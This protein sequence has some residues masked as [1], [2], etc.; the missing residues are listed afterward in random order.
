MI[1]Q[2]SLSPSAQAQSLR[3]RLTAER[4]L[5]ELRG[6]A[7]GHCA[8]VNYLKRDEA[9]ETC[10]VLQERART[11]E[12]WLLAYVLVRDATESDDTCPIT[13]DRA[14]ELRNR[15][16]GKLLLFVPPDLVDATISS[17]GNSFAEIDGRVLHRRVVEDVLDGLRPGTREAVQRV[18]RELRGGAWASD[19]SR[20]DFVLA[21]NTR[22]EIGELQLLGLEL[23]RVGFIADGGTNFDRR[24]AANRRCTRLLARPQR[25]SLSFRDRIASL[26]VAPE[27][28]QQLEEFFARRPLHDVRAWSRELAGGVGPTFD[29]W[30]FPETVQT[31]LK[32]VTVAPFTDEHHA[33]NK[34]VQLLQ[35]D[36]PG[37]ALLAPCGPKQFLSVAWQPTPLKPNN[38]QGWRAAIVEV[39]TDGEIDDSSDATVELQER[40][41]KGTAR[42][43]RLSLAIEFDQQPEARY[44][45]RVVAIDGG[46]NE[47]LDEEN[48]PLAASSQE[49]YLVKGEGQPSAPTGQR[50]RTVPSLPEGRLRAAIETKHDTIALS[51]EEW[52]NA[53]GI[54][55]YSAHVDS[56]TVVNVAFSPL[57]L[58]IERLTLRQPEQAGHYRIQLDELRRASLEDVEMIHLARRTSDAENDFWSKRKIFFDRLRHADRRDIVEVAEWTEEI[59]R[60]TV[61]YAQAYRALLEASSGDELRAI[62]TC[63]TLQIS[64]VGRHG[65]EDALLILPTH[66]LRAAWCAAHAVL[67]RSWEE[68]VLKLAA[69]RRGKAVDL[70]L[71]GELRPTNTPAFTWDSETQRPF[72]YF[73]DVAFG[74]GVALPPEA[75]DPLRRFRD[76]SV[77]VSIDQGTD[78]ASTLGSNQFTRQLREFQAVH[79][80]ADPCCLAL[81]N[82]DQGELLASSLNT[83]FDIKFDD[84]PNEIPVV[85]TFDVTAFV[86]EGAPEVLDGLGEIRTKQGE[87]RTRPTD[88]LQPGIS[89]SVR[90]FSELLSSNVPSVHLALV[91]DLSTPAVRAFPGAQADAVQPSLS[92]YG[93]IARFASEFEVTDAGPVWRY[94]IVPGAVRGE[95]HP[96][97]PIGDTLAELH[98]A[99]LS[100]TA[101]AIDVGSGAEAVPAL[102]VALDRQQT[103]LLD[104][105]HGM[106]DWVITLD[107]FVS[108]DFYDSPY[109]EALARIAQ[110]YLIDYAPEFVDGLGHRLIV[111]TAWRDEVTAILR[112]AME[113]LGFATVERSVVRLLHYLK[114]VSGRLALKALKR[115]TL[116]TEAVSLGAVTAWLEAKGRLRQSVLVPVDAH[117]G[118][119]GPATSGATQAREHHC[120]LALIGLRRGIVEA[121]LIEVKWRRGPL[122]DITDLV[123]TIEKQTRATGKAVQER[124]FN[125]Q[126]VDGALQRAYLATVL[127]FYCARS[128]RY[129]LLD[130]DEA[131]TF[132]KNVG[133]IERSGLD[134]RPS[135]EGFI[136]SLEDSGRAEILSGDFHAQVLTSRDFEQATS[137][138]MARST[139]PSSV[140]TKDACA[141][142]GAGDALPSPGHIPSI[143][144]QAT[145]TTAGSGNASASDYGPPSSAPRIILGHGLAGSEVTWDP[146]VKGSPHLFITGIPGQG[147]SWTTLHILSQLAQQGIPALVFDFHGQLGAETSSYVR[148]AHPTVVDATA[149]L[150]F[151]PFECDIDDPT[152]DYKA[153]AYAL[154]EIFDYVCKLGPIQR[155][156]LYT[157]ILSAYRACGFGKEDKELP[158]DYPSL[159]DLRFRIEAAE[160]QKQTQH[161][162]ARCREL[163]EMDAFRPRP[164]E[165][166]SLIDTARRGLVIDLHRMHSE[167]LQLAAGA[168]LL[169]KLYRDMFSWG[170]ADRLRLVITL[171]EAHRLAQDTTLPKIMKEGRKFGIAIVAASQGLADFHQ[172]VLSNAGTKIAFRA[173]YPESRKIAGYFRARPGYDIVASIEQMHV[174]QAM[175]QTPEMDSAVRTNM[176]SPKASDDALDVSHT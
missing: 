158:W 69:T 52:I 63:D 135:Y 112:H 108:V 109:E 148:T 18:Q 8:R 16:H 111:T 124:F 20:L 172:E 117:V 103:A 164:G 34:G 24:V 65:T 36:G 12:P 22:E 39:E 84:D 4:I 145:A 126:R 92:L 156:N 53:P 7:D 95:S 51:H 93:L 14:I 128:Q 115:E 61:R 25:L 149:G 133:L 163:I 170:Q 104:R 74:W 73:R 33:I 50:R 87:L 167:R 3:Q 94:R 23:W 86:H 49:F 48:R 40:E 139:P 85:P 60:T 17:L 123:S 157:C 113:D 162:L 171:D 154:A 80:Y 6:A 89:V 137:D 120:D 105:V 100:A 176:R 160:R 82:P 91:T 153:T 169:R 70:A 54:V 143:A 5:Q 83:L 131:S 76:V 19:E 32:E 37:G 161:L 2:D 129:G 66:P 175:I 57:L 99:V 46:G 155:D 31:N 98:K 62:L 1:T 150:P 114:T 58:E 59:R 152:L 9:L 68:Q 67:L 30:I 165:P 141:A 102:E 27:T 147:K 151:S 130:R 101:R 106:S 174:G 38:V 132:L 140:G 79:P 110:R 45:V 146:S 173:N 15:K 13:A 72:L 142:V 138:L 159:E 116:G 78:G 71:V 136:I 29:Q 42:K 55:Y 96:V 26:K 47:L 144:N 10:R 125:E 28:A 97:S 77:I 166:I 122:G 64:F 75:R 41:T 90:P 21:A 119:F 35:P 118:L 56:R 11:S 168:F 127:R 81:V 44:C 88:H 134:F 121:A 107:R 43:M